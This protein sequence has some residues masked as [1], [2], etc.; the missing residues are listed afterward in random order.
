MNLNLSRAV[1]PALAGRGSLGRG[2]RRYRRLHRRHLRGHAFMIHDYATGR[3]LT[4]TEKVLMAAAVR[5]AKVASAFDR[6]GTRRAK[7]V[8]EW[9]REIASLERLARARRGGGRAGEE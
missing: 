1:G 4:P 7:P 5:D 2:L 8:G 9:M 3:R 6:V